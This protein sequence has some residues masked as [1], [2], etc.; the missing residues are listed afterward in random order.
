MADV[1]DT[2]VVDTTAGPVRAL[3]QRGVWAFKGVPYGE[4]TSGEGRFKPP[5]PARPWVG[6][7]D[8]F[9]YGPS[10]PQNRWSATK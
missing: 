8:C 7:R 10:C 9:D 2:G 3:E 4:D 5:R 6:V 1:T